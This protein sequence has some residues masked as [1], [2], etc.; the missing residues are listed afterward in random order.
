MVV[1]D[2]LHISARPSGV[3]PA[4]ALRHWTKVSV[5]L[6]STTAGQ[7]RLARVFLLALLVILPGTSSFAEIRLPEVHERNCDRMIR[8]AAAKHTTLPAA[9]MTRTPSSR[10]RPHPASA[11]TRR[12]SPV[13]QT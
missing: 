12:S 11:A 2:V 8:R 5:S 3:A 10:T 6:A 1:G 7:R 9:S 13:P 4:Q